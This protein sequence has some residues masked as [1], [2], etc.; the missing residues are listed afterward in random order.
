MKICCT[1][2]NSVQLSRPII[3]DSGLASCATCRKSLMA[4]PRSSFGLSV[5]VFN[6]T[7]TNVLHKTKRWFCLFYMIYLLCLCY[8]FIFG[9]CVLNFM[10]ARE[11]IILTLCYWVVPHFVINRVEWSKWRNIGLNTVI[12]LMIWCNNK[13]V[14]IKINCWTAT[15][16]VSR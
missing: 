10:L 11:V 14:M 1:Y 6:S 2:L 5:L 8:L 4:C 15:G 12:W 3:L 7:G 9:S 13:V 16:K